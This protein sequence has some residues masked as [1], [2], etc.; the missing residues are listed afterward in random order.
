MSPR[1]FGLVA[2]LVAATLLPTAAFAQKNAASAVKEADRKAGMAEAPAIVQAAGLA[3]QV[4]DARKI[5]ETKGDKKAGTPDTKFYEVACQQGMGFSLSAPAGGAPTA[6][7]CIEANTPPAGQKESSIACKLPGNADPKAGLVPYLQA[8]KAQCTPTATRGIGQSKT[9]T[10]IEVLC[11]EGAGYVL[12]ASAP[13]DA[14]KKVEAQNCL[15]FDEGEGNVK[16]TLADKASRLAVVDRIVTDAKNNCAIKER[17]YIGA[18]TDGSSFYETSCADGKGYIYKVAS[19]GSLTQTWDCGQA[20]TILGG[21]K[22]TDARQAASEQAALYTRLAKSAGSACEVDRYAIFPT[23]GKDEVVELICK[24][25]DGGVGIFPATGAGKVLD[26][27][28]AP[29]AGYACSLNKPG[30]GNDKLT[31]DLKKFNQNSCAV[32]A[33]RLAGKTKDNTSLIEVACADGLKGY[34]IEYDAAYAPKSSIGCALAGGCK[35]PGNS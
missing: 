26:C 34:M 16:C 13:L 14:S 2:A 32:S 6:F 35:L 10:F 7:S 24:N 31:A 1:R 20:G 29:L 23:N 3:C 25:G 17:R 27:G 11:Q 8:A 9:S 21:C 33:S 19:A 5:G 12:V 22:L 28:H 30:T 4:T 18:S 15:L